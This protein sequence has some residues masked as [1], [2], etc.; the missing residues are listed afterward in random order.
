[1]SHRDVH[2]RYGLRNIKLA[3]DGCVCRARAAAA[4]VRLLAQAPAL[5]LATLVILGILESNGHSGRRAMQLGS[6]STFRM[7]EQPAQAA[8]LLGPL[9]PPCRLSVV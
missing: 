5:K 4:F 7:L 3:I 6:S 1:M 2:L 9:P 8:R